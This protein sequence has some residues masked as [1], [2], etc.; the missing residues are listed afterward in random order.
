M[1]LYHRWTLYTTCSLSPLHIQILDFCVQLVVVNVH[2]DQLLWKNQQ[3]R[4]LLYLLNYY[5]HN[6][7]TC[8][9]SFKYTFNRLKWDA[10]SQIKA[11]NNWYS[12]ECLMPWEIIMVRGGEW[13]MECFAVTSFLTY[14]QALWFSAVVKP[15]KS[16]KR[17]LLQSGFLFW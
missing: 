13:K 3:F 9:K 8:A 11:K 7:F 15:A 12:G 16:K 5:W 2:V 14:D 4:K 1:S 17:L 10:R 6:H